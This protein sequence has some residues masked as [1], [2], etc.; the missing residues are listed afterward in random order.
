[1]KRQKGLTLVEL[2]VT[3]AVAIILVAVG[4]PLFSGVAANNRAAAQTNALVSAMKL[5]RSESV[6]RRD[7]TTVCASKNPLPDTANP[8]ECSTA[9][10]PDWTNGWLVHTDANNNSS[11]DQS[12]ILRVWEGLSNSAVVTV[13][14]P[15]SLTEVDF[16]GSGQANGAFAFETDEND[17]TG[18]SND[19]AKRCVVVNGAG[20]VR[21]KRR[22]MSVS[23]TCP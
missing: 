6:R 11:F 15:G 23:W 3:L 21:T 22:D 5:A 20:Q 10:T 4:M 9:S 13:T 12:D 2:M 7:T 18:A 19:A 8:I 16:D 17:A 14:Y 1:M